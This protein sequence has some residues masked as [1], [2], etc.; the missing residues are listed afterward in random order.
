MVVDVHVHLLDQHTDMD[1]AF[2]AA[3]GHSKSGGVDLTTRWPE[4]EATATDDTVAIVF[5]GK[6]R[7]SGIWADDAKVAAFAAEHPDTVIGFMGVDPTQLGWYEG[8]VH[9]HRE[10]GLRGMKIMP[11]YAGFDP[12]D[13]AFDPLWQYASDNG[14]PIVTHTGTTFV[15]QAVLDYA[16]PVLFDRV[17]R[18]FPDLKLVLAHLG[19]P[20]EGECLATIRKN[21]NVYADLSALHY[22][23]FQLWHS[24][25]LA[26]DYGVGHKILF[27]T[28]YPFTTVTGTM[29]A[30]RALTEVEIRG[31]PTLD[32][33]LVEGIIHRDALTLL[34]LR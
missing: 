3:S 24:L 7:L 14:L 11:M 27:G 26:Q 29:D 30:L 13:E 34:G 25:R 15:P 23:P 6:A 18:R 5:G 20:Y 12:S 17:A 9:A 32:P 31:L 22:R 16:R 10:L 1:E 21:P 33:E 2:I 19:H 4:Y 8:M 28:D